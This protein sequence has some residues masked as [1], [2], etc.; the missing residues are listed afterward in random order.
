[1]DSEGP[2]FGDDKYYTKMRGRK[3]DITEMIG[4]DKRY[5]RGQG[6]AACGKH[7]SGIQG[8]ATV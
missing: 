7:T 4:K 5:W 8:V 2:T 6:F 3:C 1:M